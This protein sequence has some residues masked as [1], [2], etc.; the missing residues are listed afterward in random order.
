VFENWPPGVKLVGTLTLPRKDRPVPAVLLCAGSGSEDRN[1]AFFPVLAD[2]LTRRG[3]A[4]LRYDKRGIWKS[5]GDFHAATTADLA[6]DARAGIAYL[7]SRPEIDPER[8]G[9]IGHSEGAMIAQMLASEAP[10]V[11]FVVLMAGPGVPLDELLVSQRCL[12]AKLEGAG[13]DK[14]SFLR[15]WYRRFYAT[16]LEEKNDAAAG[17]TIRKAYAGLT[18]GER[19]MLGWS[20]EWLDRKIGDVLA[21]WSRQLLAFDPR[22]LLVKVKCPVLA[23]NG[24]KDMQV[25]AAENLGGIA[26]GLTAAGNTQFTVR[27]L[28]GLNHVFQTAKSGAESEYSKIEE[29]IAPMALETIGA[30]LLQTTGGSVRPSPHAAEPHGGG[31]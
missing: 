10:A 23:L 13:E 5:T 7:E 12:E 20:P 6:A 26:A 3:I 1:L 16:A 9:L 29:S 24:T 21:P 4:T 22:P 11:A 2:D 31:R 19:E 8:V 27:E 18:E 14:I 17:A 28:P 15:D 30:W 25:S